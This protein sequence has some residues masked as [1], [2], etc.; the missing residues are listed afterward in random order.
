MTLGLCACN[1]YLRPRDSVTRL[2]FE[3]GYYTPLDMIKVTLP[4]QIWLVI[5]ISLWVPVVGKIC[6]FI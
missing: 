5:L 4:L 2:T 6:K 3:T 1:N